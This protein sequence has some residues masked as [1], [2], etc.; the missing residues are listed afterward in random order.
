M[1]R[2]IL[3]CILITV[4]FSSAVSAESLEPPAGK[5]T[6]NSVIL[7]PALDVTGGHFYD[8]LTLFFS[9]VLPPS[10]SD[11][12]LSQAL[13]IAQD[14]SLELK[15]A[16]SQ[17]EQSFYKFQELESGKRV[18]VS[19]TA[20]LVYNGPL[21]SVEFAGNKMALGNDKN[22]STGLQAQYLLSNFGL[23]EDARR[24]A[25]LAYT[26]ASF[27]EERVLAELYRK[28]INSY[29]DTLEDSGFYFVANQGL[30]LRK[31]QYS[32]AELRFN[33]G[34]APRYDLL[35]SR[36]AVKDA[37]QRVTSA[38]KSME[39]RKS[40]LKNILGLPQ[41]REIS[42]TAPYYISNISQ[43]LDENV[44]LAWC[45]RIELI[46]TD[47]SVELAKLGI[48]IAAQKKNPTLALN[49]SYSLQSESFGRELY[50]W[51]ATVALNVPVVDGGETKAL[52]N[53]AKEVHK[54]SLLSREQLKKDLALAVQNAL[55]RVEESRKKLETAEASIDAA[56]EAYDIS[57][58]RYREGI[59]T[60]LEL[61]SST[62]SYI[63]SLVSLSSA[64]CEYERSKA[65][66]LYT[67][68][69]LINEVKN[70]VLS[71]NI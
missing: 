56:Q 47:L 12:T 59:G 39:E 34:V 54:Q 55:L 48:D 66:L 2:Y 68:G 64:Y 28:T 60:F 58:L 26:V 31:K 8:V 52:V 19:G 65:H 33:N 36:L 71:K 67:V 16:H 40:L 50:G 35:T 29:F 24:S 42:I 7:K 38:Y 13:I 45:N 44:S 61:D 6:E 49:A 17:R 22:W 20:S 21:P 23:F 32:T 4:I 14:N 69:L 43:N 70:N 18:K 3:F 41:Q 15:K 46:Q 62:V 1:K 53:Q 63:S 25:Y 5:P 37:E 10:I 30:E 9:R 57:Y 27:E 11:L 51:S